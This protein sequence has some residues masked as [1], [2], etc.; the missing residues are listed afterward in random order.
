MN[1]NGNHTNYV[2]QDQVSASNVQNLQVAW[3]FPFPAAYNVP[4]LAVTGEGSIS[5][6][7]VV[8]GTVFV[9]TNFLT[10]YAING[11]TGAVV[12]SYVA[13]LNTTGLPL[14]PLVGHM[15]G[16]NYYRGDLWVNLPDCSVLALNALSGAVVMRIRDICAGI[17]GNAGFYDSSGVPPVFDGDTMIWTSSVSEGTDVGRGFVAAYDITDGQLLW[18]WYVAPPAGGDPNWDADSCSV[19]ATSSCHGN[20][21]PYVG[22]WGGMGM[23][24]TINGTTSHPLAG[25]GPSF[26]CTG[27]RYETRRGLRVHVAA[28]SGL[29]RDLQARA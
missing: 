28:L 16:M 21:S 8:N 22:D 1:A 9:L 3:T 4:G 17:P 19:N 18:R 2:P 7:L 13:Q 20:V 11:E 27:R 12:W 24:T 23:T 14:G 6:P 25:A 15:H 29:E 5:P 10:V 26:G